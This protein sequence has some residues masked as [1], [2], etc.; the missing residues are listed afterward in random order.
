MQQDIHKKYLAIDY[1]QKRIGLAS[2]VIFPAGLG[3]IDAGKGRDFV[4]A[5]IKKITDEEDF[6]G[7]VIGLP[8]RS[9]GEGGTL[10]SEIREFAGQ[11]YQATG[12]NIYFEEEEFSSSEAQNLF[13][14][15]NKKIQRKSGDV[16][17]MAAI[18]ILERFFDHVKNN[19]NIKPDISL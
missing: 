13:I 16:D 10:D 4:L 5:E 19:P 18:I 8:V 6:S 9:Q 3:V 2:G 11:I 7:I 12:L 17:E 15:H 14:A 1:G